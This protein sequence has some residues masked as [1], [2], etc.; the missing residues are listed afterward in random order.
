MTNFPS[1][2]RR[3]ARAWPVPSFVAVTVTP[4]ST[5]FPLIQDDARELGPSPLGECRER[6]AVTIRSS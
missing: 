3:P 5:A 4:G 2:G 6:A 1:A